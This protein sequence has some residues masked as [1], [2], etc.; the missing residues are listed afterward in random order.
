VEMV[1]DEGES[2]QEIASC[3][4]I[5]F[6]ALSASSLSPVERMLWAVETELNDEY[7][8][9]EGI[10]AFWEQHH[11]AADW[12][13]LA[14]KLMQRLNNFDDPEGGDSFLRD[15]HRDNLTDWIITALENAGRGDEVIP[16]CEQETKKTHS[17]VRLVNCLVE[18]KRSE[19]AE[20]WIR[21]GVEATRGTLPGIDIALHNI[22]CR[23]RE[24]EKNWL[25]AASL[26]AD[27]FF[28]NPSLETFNGLQKSAEKAGVW[29]EVRLN[30]MRF[31]ETG[32]LPNNKT[33]SDG[34]IPLYPLSD[35]GLRRGVK[36]SS[37]NF[38]AIGLLIDIAIAENRPDEV[39]RWYDQTGKSRH[40]WIWSR[41]DNIAQAIAEAYP[42]RAVSIWKKLAEDCIAQTNVHAYEQA[43]GYL[44]CVRDVFDA[45]GRGEEWHG[46]LNT[47]RQNNARKRSLMEILDSIERHR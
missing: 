29:L 12:N 45:A 33:I 15:Y 16:L 40:N 18:E 35:T 27:D 46:Y 10:T 24:D 23:M 21:K 17:Y 6:K 11:A 39:V 4:D 41:E 13:T 42:E 32:E 7:E 14:E 9:C 1:D 37:S 43:A 44:L 28:D 8:F 26:R 5:V 36:N 31:L 20:Q 2:V 34:A 22:L 30:V 25:D 3:M 47:L 38:P 19:E